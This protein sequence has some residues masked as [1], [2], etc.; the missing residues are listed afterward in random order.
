MLRA[1]Y[2]P[3]RVGE[4]R[5]ESGRPDEADLVT[6]VLDIE[7]VA[8]AVGWVVTRPVAWWGVIVVGGVPGWAGSPGQPVWW[9]RMVRLWPARIQCHSARTLSWPR[10]RKRVIRRL[11]LMSPK[12]GS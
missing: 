1:S 10:R 6:V 4:V 8:L 3:A 12:T 11:V 5:T 9:W 2:P 7:A